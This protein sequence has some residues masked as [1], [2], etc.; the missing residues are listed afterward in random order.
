MIVG[1]NPINMIFC[2]N[3][4]NAIFLT[5]NT[6][7]YIVSVMRGGS[8]GEGRADSPHT[9]TE[10]TPWLHHHVAHEEVENAECSIQ[11]RPHQA[12]E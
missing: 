1:L 7:L 2:V 5:G 9:R 8:K 11:S 10:Q 12:D 6:K 4:V 3:K